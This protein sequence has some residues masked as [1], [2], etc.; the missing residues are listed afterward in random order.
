[1]LVVGGQGLVESL[2]GEAELQAGDACTLDTF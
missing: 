1:M 2:S